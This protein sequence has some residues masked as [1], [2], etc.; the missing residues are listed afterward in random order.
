MLKKFSK[1]LLLV[2]LI[3]VV[4]TSSFIALAHE[5]DEISNTT[6]SSTVE[7]TTTSTDIEANIHNGDLYLFDTDI[8]MDKLVNGNVFIFGNNIEITGQIHGNLFVFANSVNFNESVVSYSTFVCANSVYFN[9]LCGSYSDYGNL[10]VAAKKFEATYNSCVTGDIKAVSSDVILKSVI[11]KDIN[12]ICDN[13][14]FGEGEDIPNIYGNLNYTSN[15]EKTIPD[16]VMLGNGTVT[17]TSPFEVNINALSIADTLIS[18]ASCIIT[19]LVIYILINKFTPKFTEKLANQNFSIIKLLKNFGIGIVSIFAVSILFIA[20]LLTTVGVKLAFILIILFIVLCLI[21]APVLSIYITNLLKTT[22]KIEKNSMFYLVLSLV[23]II[24]YGITYIPFIGGLLGFVIT[25]T[26]L[27]LIIDMYLPH[28]ELTEEEKLA[29]E[30]AK[31]QAKE[32][33]EKR[34][35]ERLEEKAIK[36]QKKLEANEEKKK[37]KKENNENN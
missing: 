1:F 2:L 32:N 37:N 31:K 9:G 34:K 8:I 36:T 28:K 11:Y 19:A 12:L 6:T 17:Y 4:S 35:Q 26:G 5:E 13:I 22:L 7:D 20:L 24:L 30:E 21:S 15:I 27:G 3:F 10:Y 33:K 14:D 29:L 18:F 23:S 25:I 16:G